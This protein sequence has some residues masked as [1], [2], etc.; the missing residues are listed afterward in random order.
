MSTYHCPR[1]AEIASR[2]RDRRSEESNSK[3]KKSIR[4]LDSKAAILARIDERS[5]I[6]DKIVFTVGISNNKS[7]RVSEDGSTFIFTQSGLY[8]IVFKGKVTSQGK[9]V[10]RRSPPLNEKQTVFTKF[11]FGGEIQ[12]VS[13]MLPF[14][15]SYEL[16][17]IFVANKSSKG[18]Y[19]EAGA[20]VEIYKVDEI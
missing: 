12:E 1:C 19:L 7:F 18:D 15:S 2:K 14:H 17:V 20:Q 5:P 16:T 8:R 6:Q 3:E 9:I 4:T 10:L 13:T 11:A